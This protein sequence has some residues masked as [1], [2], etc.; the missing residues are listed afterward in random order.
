VETFLAKAAGVAASAAVPYYM[1]A[2]C[3]L[4]RA[5]EPGAILTR[6]SVEPPA[7]SALWRLRAEQDRHFFGA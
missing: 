5:L 7:G 4:T 6:D 1:A 3:T 2:G